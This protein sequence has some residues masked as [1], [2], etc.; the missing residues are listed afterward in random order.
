MMRKTFLFLI[1]IV[2]TTG[3]IAQR[4]GGG[5][6]RL[7][8]SN[9]PPE[10]IVIGKVKDAISGVPMEYANVVLFS[11]RDSTMAA[12]TVS[13]ADGTFRMEKVPFGR[14]YLV[15]NFIGYNKLQV[16]DIMINPRNKAVDIGE[17]QLQPSAKNLESVEITAEREHFE[18]KIDKK[19]VNVEK[20]IMAQGGTAVNALENVPSVEVD[21]DGNVSMRGSSSFTVLI[22]GRPSVLQGTD[23]LQQIPVSNIDNIEIITNPSAKYDPDGVAGII[24]VILK[25]KK[26]GGL[27]GIINASVASGDKYNADFLLNYRTGKFNIFGG[28]D[29][30]QHQ[31]TGDRESNTET[32][33]DDTTQFRFSNGTRNR[34]RDGY[35]VRLGADFF[36]TD[37]T[38]ISVLGR[39]GYYSRGGGYSSNMHVFTD[40]VS[41]DEYSITTSNG[42]TH[43]QKNGSGKSNAISNKNLRCTQ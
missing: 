37:K 12:G 1:L 6:G 13:D 16:E 23:A 19:V 26:A 35:G 38:T 24:N 11:L 42:K 15:A 7:G 21:I 4:P 29:Y 31:H 20:D 14:F 41:R 25:D 17:I 27:T 36:A 22:D 43:D 28:A 39:M 8:Q 10:G 34:T 18:Y 32:Y 40:P 30:R 3:T 9:M 2:I 5:G 33:W